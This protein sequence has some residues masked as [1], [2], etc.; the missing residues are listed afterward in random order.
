MILGLLVL[1]AFAVGCA[2]GSAERLVLDIRRSLP[3]DPEHGTPVKI[4]RVSD[5]RVFKQIPKETKRTTS[6]PKTWVNQKKFGFVPQLETGGI[7]DHATTVRAVGQLRGISGNVDYDLLLPEG[8]SVEVLTQE[9]LTEAFR[10]AGYRVLGRGDTGYESSYAVEVDIE[11]FWAWNTVPRSYASSE[12]IPAV[13]KDDYYKFRFRAMLRID[14]MLEHFEG[15][16]R[17]EGEVL[18]HGFAPSPQSY[19]NTINKGLADLV[20][21]LQRELAAVKVSNGNLGASPK[22]EPNAPSP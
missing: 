19:R 1:Q 7:H 16:R 10:T 12:I 17:V 8:R 13:S 2:A 4:I 15:K 11:E 3:A 18:L 6:D 21:N 20:A 22:A 5:R 14:L 9:A